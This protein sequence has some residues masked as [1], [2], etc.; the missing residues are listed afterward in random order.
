MQLSGRETGSYRV[1]R[2]REAAA[3]LRLI[4]DQRYLAA[5]LVE[6]FGQFHAHQLTADDGDSE[7]MLVALAQSANGPIGTTGVVSL[8]SGRAIGLSAPDET[9]SARYSE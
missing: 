1:V 3:K 7:T 2:R 5:A 8:R 6:E 9:A 4:A